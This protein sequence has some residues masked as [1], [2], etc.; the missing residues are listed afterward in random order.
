[1][2]SPVVVDADEEPRQE[3]NI[4]NLL[5]NVVE[6]YEEVCEYISLEDLE[7]IQPSL[8]KLNEVVTQEIYR[9]IYIYLNLISKRKS[10]K[11]RKLN[12]EVKELKSLLQRERRQ[13]HISI[14]V[15]YQVFVIVNRTKQTF[16]W[17][18][19]FQIVQCEI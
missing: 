13:I 6:A 15:S 17:T 16:P 1:M 2:A 11:I 4:T 18:W 12:S 9:V 19:R 8:S 10:K 3:I 5:E 7:W 14:H